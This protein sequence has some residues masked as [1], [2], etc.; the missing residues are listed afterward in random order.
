MRPLESL[1]QLSGLIYGL[2]HQQQIQPYLLHLFGFIKVKIYLLTL[3]GRKSLP[4][5][6]PYIIKKLACI[7]R[8]AIIG[9]SY[10]QDSS[11]VF[12]LYH[13]YGKFCLCWNIARIGTLDNKQAC[14]IISHSHDSI[15]YSRT[16]GNSRSS[17]HISVGLTLHIT[18]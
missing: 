11:R 10:Y 6:I 17:Q 3:N 18:I 15:K 9:P 4:V 1:H 13:I 16:L 7:N 2:P 5:I 12:L 14:N 8:T